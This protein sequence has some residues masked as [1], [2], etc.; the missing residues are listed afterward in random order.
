MALLDL[1]LRP[2]DDQ[3][4]WFGLVWFPALC[5]L[6]GTI[7]AVRFDSQL[8]ASCTA[9]AGLVGFALGALAPRYLVPVYAGLLV[10]VFPIGLVVSHLLVAFVYY[11][12]ITPIGL[13][14]R[15][16]GRDAL[17]RTI[18]REATSYW[19]VR[20]GRPEAKRYFRQF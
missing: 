1:E 19:I 10:A 16:T 4:R 13:I 3:L 8:V 14:L 15:L 17:N 7:A 6:V 11:A 20:T 12:C 2:P 9:V 18:D 5:L